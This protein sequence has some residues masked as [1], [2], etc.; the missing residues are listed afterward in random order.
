MSSSWPKPHLLERS[1][2]ANSFG[3][4]NASL[5]KT[6]PLGIISRSD[7]CLSLAMLQNSK[8]HLKELLIWRSSFSFLY[9]APW[10]GNSMLSDAAHVCWGTSLAR[11]MW[12]P[13]QVVHVCGWSSVWEPRD[14]TIHY[15]RH[16]IAPEA[17]LVEKKLPKHFWTTSFGAS[18]FH[19]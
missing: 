18:D 8:A 13:A 3:K 15:T 12:M 11:I 16:D 19:R 10:N 5:H 4:V 17:D 7:A 1:F 6:L 14:R 9:I 2:P